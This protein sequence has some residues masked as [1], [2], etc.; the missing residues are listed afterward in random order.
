M[1]DLNIHVHHITRVEGHGDIVVNA[2]DGKIEDIRWEINE[3]PRFFEAMLKGRRYDEASLLTSRICGICAVGH[4]TASVQATEAAMGLEL[5]EQAQLLRKLNFH[6]EM[7]ESHFLHTYF[8][9]APDVFRAPSVIPL[10]ATHL[11]VVQ[12]ALRLKKLGNTLSDAICGRKLH[13]IAMT[14]GGWTFTPTEKT[15][16]ALKQTILDHVDDVKATVELFATIQMPDLQRETEYISLKNDDEYAFIEGDICSSDAGRT[17]LNDYKSVTNEFLV[18]HSTSKW[19]KNKRSSYMV[20][21]LARFNNNS[22]QLNAQGKAT[23]EALGLVAPNYNPFMNNVAQVVEAVHCAYDAVEIIDKL[24]DNG[25]KPESPDVQVKA[26]RGVGCTDVPRG[27]LFHDYTYDADGLITDANCIIP[28]GQ[29]HANIEDD[30]RH[31]VP[32]IIDKGQDEVRFLLEMLVRAYDPCISCSVH[33][34]NVTF[35]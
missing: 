25:I 19:A 15:L 5:T 24:L 34:L 6:G 2:K 13:P 29:N 35:V 3:A 31:W 4:A 27:I 1:K 7:L 16:R 26:G 30:M 28:T 17:P 18:P 14:P 11:E 23:A 10:A 20:G 21:A 12:R 8:L 9:V 33:M 22:D 32:Q